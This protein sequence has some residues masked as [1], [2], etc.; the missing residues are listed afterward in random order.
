MNVKILKVSTGELEDALI[1]KGIKEEMPSIQDNWRFNF[2]KHSQLPNS[3][4][5]VLVAEETPTI[6]EGCLIFQMKNKEIPYM[7]FVEV[8]P[9]NR[10][11]KKRHDF[12]AGCL[13]AFAFKQS[14]EQAEGDYKGMLFFDV[15]EED[16][17]NE[18]KLMVNYSKHYNA[19]IYSG[20]T[21]III[22]E[23]GDELIQKYLERK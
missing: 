12:V 3:I 9:H 20:T 2:V 14:Y 18:K 21:M 19:A 5:Y 4:A 7:A 13:I 23:G 16:P 8:A 17:V 6:I 22:D 10:G 11:D 1:R 15:Q